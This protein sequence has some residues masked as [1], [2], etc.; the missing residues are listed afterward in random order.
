MDN[1]KSPVI[2]A[3]THDL[4]DAELGKRMILM[5]KVILGGNPLAL[6]NVKLALMVAAKLHIMS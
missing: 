4:Q 2:M 6:L 3:E 1:V 5:K